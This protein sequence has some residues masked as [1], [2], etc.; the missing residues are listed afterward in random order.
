MYREHYFTQ[1][2]IENLY[3]LKR[4]NAPHIHIYIYILHLVIFYQIISRFSKLNIFK[5]A[6][7][8]LTVYLFVLYNF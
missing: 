1:I 3:E 4:G 6:L 8:Y 2:L 5:T 7:G